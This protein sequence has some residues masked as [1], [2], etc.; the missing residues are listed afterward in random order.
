MRKV[1]AFTLVE[2]LVVI[3][4]IALLISILLPALQKAKQSAR[5]VA[6]LSNLRQL[7]TMIALY[8]DDSRGCLP[9]NELTSGGDDYYYF[10]AYLNFLARS[11][12]PLKLLSCPDDDGDVRLFQ[13]G[14]A[15]SIGIASL[16]GNPYHLTGT[17]MVRI[18]YGLNSCMA[19]NDQTQYH[20]NKIVAWKQAARVV[21]M[22][23]SANYI[24]D[25]NCVDRIVGSSFGSRWPDAVL[26]WHSV[27][28]TFARHQGYDNILFLDGHAEPMSSGH[29]ADS[30]IYSQLFGALDYTWK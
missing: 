9:F 12:V 27:P 22:A 16:S 1:R 6:C 3:G 21:L 7:G 17:E 13:S 10:H 29:G 11:N 26:G 24:F 2:L 5:K 23:D 4:I 25:Y 30:P 20:A 15:G 19:D 28:G 8:V 18:S 14:G